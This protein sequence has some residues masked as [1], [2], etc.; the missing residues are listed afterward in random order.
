MTTEAGPESL[1]PGRVASI[2]SP[3]LGRAVEVAETRRLSAGASRLSWSVDIRAGA[4]PRGLVLQ[5]ER[6]KGLGR[7]RM[8]REA[9]LLRAA[10]AAGV[11]VPAVVAADDDPAALGGGYLVTER[12]EGETIPRRILRDPALA[13]ARAGFAAQCGQILTRIHAIPLGSLPDLPRPDPIDA[14]AEMLDNTGQSRPAFEIGLAWLREHPARQRAATLV[15][16]DFRNGN[17]VVGPDGIQAV[18]DWE[19]AQAGNPMQDL[20]WLC[21][22]P[23][24]WGALPPVGGIGRVED[25]LAAYSPADGP[26]SASEL[27]WW[28]LLSSVR[29]GVMGLEQARV[30]LS[31]EHRSV[32]L[33]VLGRLSSEME[34]D[35]LR[36]VRD[37]R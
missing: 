8:L 7:S 33:A 1:D 15:H 27:F 5:R 24:R 28:R 34:Y 3:V 29:W 12:I 17:L 16:G 14:L 26:V 35:V 11:P 18:L 2:L 32:E 25:L 13:P 20:G 31:G 4:T 30:H 21:A 36:M 22:R 6:A 10:A 19:L 23:W 37:G 9:A